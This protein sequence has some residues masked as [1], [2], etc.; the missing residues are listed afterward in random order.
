MW[1]SRPNNMLPH[2]G[3]TS[4][5]HRQPKQRRDPGKMTTNEATP[6]D[7]EIHRGFFGRW[8]SRAPRIGSAHFRARV[9]P[10]QDLLRQHG[11]CR[12]LRTDT[13]PT[14]SICCELR[15]VP[16]AANC[17]A[18]N[19]IDLLHCSDSAEGA[20]RAAAAAVATRAGFCERRHH[21]HHRRAPN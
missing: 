16:A 13:T 8:T 6:D 15:L 14:S 17:D 4:G 10:P 9:S 11:S 3:R 7:D 19:I 20:A 18:T 12:L 21:Q 5:G 2:R 1:A